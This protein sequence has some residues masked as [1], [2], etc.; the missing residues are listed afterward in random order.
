MP[1]NRRFSKKLWL[2]RAP[3]GTEQMSILPLHIP[4][5]TQ[6]IIAAENMVFYNSLCKLI[7]ICL[8]NTATLHLGGLSVLA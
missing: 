6:K 3:C 1:M 2:R 8:Q 4:A 5:L 7:D